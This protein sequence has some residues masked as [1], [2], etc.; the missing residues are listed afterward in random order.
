LYEV[1]GGRSNFVK[2]SAAEL[3]IYLLNGFFTFVKN[4]SRQRQALIDQDYLAFSTS[5]NGTGWRPDI[6]T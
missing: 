3:A 4:R 5:C 6:A 1:G 2:S